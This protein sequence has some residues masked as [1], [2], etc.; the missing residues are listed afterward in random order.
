MLTD[1]YTY[2]ILIGGLMLMTWALIC[3]INGDVNA[4]V[5]GI[6]FK[7]CPFVVGLINLLAAMKLLGAL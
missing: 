2:S 1:F 7:L 6:I 5:A 4:W 3:E